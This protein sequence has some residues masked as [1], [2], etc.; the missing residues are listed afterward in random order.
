ME[1]TTA[2]DWPRHRPGRQSCRTA[3]SAAQPHPSSWASERDQ[4][5]NYRLQRSRIKPAA[6]KSWTRNFRWLHGTGSVCARFARLP[7]GFFNNSCLYTIWSWVF[8]NPVYAWTI[9]AS[10]CEWVT[11]CALFWWNFWMGKQGRLN[12]ND[13]A[14]TERCYLSSNNVS[15][16]SLWN[17][18]QRLRPCKDLA[19]LFSKM[20]SHRYSIYTPLQPYCNSTH[21]IFDW[22]MD[23]PFS[24]NTS[25]TINHTV[26]NH[27]CA[28]MRPVHTASLPRSRVGV[29]DGCDSPTPPA[30]LQARVRWIAHRVKSWMHLEPSHKRA[31]MYS[32][33]CPLS[34]ALPHHL[35]AS[36]ILGNGNTYTCRDHDRNWQIALLDYPDRRACRMGIA[37]FAH[38]VLMAS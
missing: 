36:T 23:R 30:S 7:E 26:A 13:H 12:E 14:Q 5:S 19:I 31:R 4:R 37:D 16:D 28:A 8:P 29:R 21:L 22:E 27:K 20:I 33:L 1:C 2:R 38:N 17:L 10:N 32:H 35:F 15:R 25:L 11:M 9:C 3:S 24:T 6:N 34:N 18:S